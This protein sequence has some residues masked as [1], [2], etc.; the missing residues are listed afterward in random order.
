MNKN[1]FITIKNTF[2]IVLISLLIT[3]FSRGFENIV[4]LNYFNNINLDKQ[5]NSYSL[6]SKNYFFL[7]FIIKI[8]CPLFISIFI[9]FLLRNRFKMKYNFIYYIIMIIVFYMIFSK[10]I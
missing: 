2:L 8:I 3:I 9:F 6:I 10:I 1:T 5:D 7:I 4:T